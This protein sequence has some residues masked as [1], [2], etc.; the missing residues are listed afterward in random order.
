MKPRE[1]KSVEWRRV[2]RKTPCPIC[3]KPDWCTVAGVINR[4]CCMR[5]E[6]PHPSK[7]AMGGWL[8]PLDTDVP[9]PELPPRQKPVTINAPAIWHG[10]RKQTTPQQMKDMAENVGVDPIALDQIG[11]CYAPSHQAWAFPMTNGH[12]RIVGIRLRNLQGDKWAVTGSHQGLFV[13]R[14]V[15]PGPVYLCE[16]PTDTA[17]GLSIGLMTIGRP[18][19]RGCEMDVVLTLNRLKSK[20][21]VI[22]ADNDDPGQAGA[23][24][25][26]ESLAIPSIIWTPPCKDLR[27]FVNTG[28]NAE[29]IHTQTKDLIGI[30]NP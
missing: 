28:G 5:I 13:P 3:H 26:K 21:A 2:T 12:G 8:H 17:A 14:I 4:V 7:N 15:L 23:R 22:V 27:E 30:A 16:G 18:A 6:S 9:L 10:W 24:K 25:L 1:N 11:A 20:Q 29:L 19:C